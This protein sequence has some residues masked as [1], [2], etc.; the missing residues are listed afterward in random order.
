MADNASMLLRPFFKLS[1]QCFGPKVCVTCLNPSAVTAPTPHISPALSQAAFHR[2]PVIRFCLIHTVP[3]SVACQV[4]LKHMGCQV[5]CATPSVEAAL[6][7]QQKGSERGS[8]SDQ[9][10]DV[11]TTED[12]LVVTN[13]PAT[14]V[15]AGDAATHSS[16]PATAGGATVVERVTFLYT[17]ADGACPRSYGVN[18]AQL[19]GRQHRRAHAAVDLHCCWC[20][21]PFAMG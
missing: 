16:R 3:F 9:P 7:S 4:S 8:A 19:A 17:L 6:P 11:A 5:E 20:H 14:V 2:V 15:T 18:V 12:G 10:S 1:N 13:G 21:F